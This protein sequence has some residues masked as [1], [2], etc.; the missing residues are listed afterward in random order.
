MLVRNG[1]GSMRE[2]VLGVAVVV[3]LC[4]FLSKKVPGSE[5]QDE[6]EWFARRRRLGR[7]RRMS[8]E[9]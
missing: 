1:L 7:N 9:C 5:P 6:Y 4:A 3:Q 2:R 8:R